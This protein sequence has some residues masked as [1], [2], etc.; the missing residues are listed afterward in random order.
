M[1]STVRFQYSLGHTPG[2]ASV[3]FSKVPHLPF[4]TFFIPW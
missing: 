3:A 1:L 4:Q 2:L